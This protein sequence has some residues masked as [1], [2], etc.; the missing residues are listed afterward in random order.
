MKAFINR[1]LEGDCLDLLPALPDKSV[2]MIL[3]DLPYGITQNPWDRII[4]MEKLWVQYNRII[5]DTGVVALSGQG[6][7]TARLI[8]ANE[9]HYKYKII[10][11]KSDPTNFLNAKK[12]PLRR[13]EDIC[14]FYKHQPVYHPQMAKGKP[15]DKGSNSSKQSGSYGQYQARRKINLTGIRYPN[16]VLWLEEVPPEDWVYFLTAKSEG[17]VYHPTQ[18][19]VELGRYLI[20]TYTNPGAIVLDNAC[21]SGSFLVAAILEKRQFVGMELNQHAFQLKVREVDFIQ[22]C[23]ER[24]KRAYRDLHNES[25]KLSLFEE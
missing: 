4:D 11:I 15:Y 17:A 9:Q 18:K 24:I 21:G 14:I 12:Q 10:W 25:I 20:R 19:P 1:V 2:D 23:E 5:K 13:H 16:D 3:C 7:F 8:L 6:A 22:I